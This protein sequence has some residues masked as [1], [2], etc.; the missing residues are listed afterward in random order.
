M[1]LTAVAV[2][3]ETQQLAEDMENLPSRME[4]TILFSEH[5]E[6]VLSTSPRTIK[7]KPG[8]RKKVTS[9]S[10]HH[11]EITGGKIKNLFDVPRQRNPRNK[12]RPPSYNEDDEEFDGN[13]SSAEASGSQSLGQ[14]K[15]PY[16]WCGKRFTRK[17]DVKRHLQNA[18]VHKADVPQDAWSPTRCRKCHAELSRVDACKRHEARDACWKRTLPSK[19]QHTNQR[20]EEVCYTTAFMELLTICLRLDTPH[21]V[22]TSIF[23]AMCHFMLSYYFVCSDE[24]SGDE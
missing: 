18:A 1:S 7:K 22:I 6:S 16:Q 13:G 12:K 8:L 4:S 3:I 9:I 19:K 2:S 23:K 5:T 15:C 11:P 24:C 20:E 21:V 10:R 14:H 17:S